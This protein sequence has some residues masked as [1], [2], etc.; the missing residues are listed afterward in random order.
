M[1]HHKCLFGDVIFLIILSGC[2]SSQ[3]DRLAYEKEIVWHVGMRVLLALAGLAMD[4]L[5]KVPA[6]LF[7]NFPYS[8]DEVY[9]HLNGYRLQSWFL[10]LKYV[11]NRTL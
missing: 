2:S 4:L 5:C 8:T 10:C 9:A 6:A 11:V 3:S 7:F 1:L